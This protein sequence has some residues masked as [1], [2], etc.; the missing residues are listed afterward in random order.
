MFDIAAYPARIP[1]YTDSAGRAELINQ[2]CSWK[3]AQAGPQNKRLHG[4][5]LPLDTPYVPPRPSEVAPDTPPEYILPSCDDIIDPEWPGLR[6]TRRPRPAQF[7]C[8]QPFVCLA[9]PLRHPGPATSQVWTATF[10]GNVG[11]EEPQLVVKLY[12]AS[13]LPEFLDYT[14]DRVAARQRQW[15]YI[16]QTF[17]AE[18]VSYSRM[19]HLQGSVVPHIFGF[20]RVV[21]PN[22]EPVIALVMERIF[23][24]PVRPAAMWQKH[25]VE[26]FDHLTR[27]LF[28]AYRRIIACG[29]LSVFVTEDNILWPKNAL[30]GETV[31]VVIDYGR[32]RAVDE[33][34][35]WMPRLWKVYSR[36]DRADRKN[37]QRWIRAKIRAGSEISKAY[38]LSDH[39]VDLIR[40]LWGM[41]YQVRA[42]RH[43]L[44]TS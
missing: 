40:R 23:G 38:Q 34:I 33:P 8:P 18:A 15:E 12:Q 4:L 9:N 21:L 3:A 30:A 28:A 11:S 25:T 6:F 2:L 44:V 31:P 1:P 41:T 29:V 43:I 20:F 36:E 10:D 27:P 13:Q 7:E 16:L 19:E 26:E 42:G 39:D 24:D 32:V 37:C 22:N 17:E 5:K 35:D 14:L